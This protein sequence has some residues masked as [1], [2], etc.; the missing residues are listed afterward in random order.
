MLVEAKQQ[1]CRA[2]N[3]INVKYIRFRMWVSPFYKSDLVRQIILQTSAGEI[4]FRF[5]TRPDADMCNIF[6]SGAAGWSSLSLGACELATFSDE[7]SAKF[8]TYKMGDPMTRQMPGRLDISV[9]K[10]CYHGWI[11]AL[12]IDPN[13]NE[14]YNARFIFDSPDDRMRGTVQR[15]DLSSF[16]DGLRDYFAELRRRKSL[17]GN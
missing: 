7:A 2:I 13:E 10:L 16:V 15:E 17:G 6:Y 12:S 14:K 8:E 11:F 5:Y 9:V 1:I 4:T 3:E